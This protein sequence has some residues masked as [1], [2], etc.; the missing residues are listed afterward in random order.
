MNIIS[1]IIT[2]FFAIVIGFLLNKTLAGRIE[3]R[4]Q[5]IAFQVVSYIGLVQ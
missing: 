1:G 5:K 4:T 2:V 3:K